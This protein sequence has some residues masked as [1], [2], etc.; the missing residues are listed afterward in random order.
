MR[1]PTSVLLAVLAAAGLL[2]FAP[3]LVRRYDA[4]ERLVAERALSTAR[5]LAR[6]GGQTHRR[7]RTVPGRRPINPP[8]FVVPRMAGGVG[9]SSAAEGSP[10]D[11]P[12]QP[13]KRAPKHLR[14]PR[15]VYRRRRVFAALVLLNLVELVGVV[16]VGP[17]FW[18]SAGFTGLLLVAY[19]AHLRNRAMLEQRR[20]RA[21]ARYAAWV[22]A[23]QAAVR[24]EQARRAAARRELLR[25]QL[26]EREEARREAARVAGQSAVR[27]RAYEARAVG[28]D[29]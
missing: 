26:L 12:R 23:R 25:Q 21:E 13:I 16:V 15:A 19:T 11:P 18:I 24:R 10:S 22:A 6:I 1:V 9:V 20:R 28:Q 29:W 4:T 2:A 17:G 5:V 27:G 14:H 8:R 7:R 3:A